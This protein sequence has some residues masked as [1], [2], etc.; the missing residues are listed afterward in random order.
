MERRA[1]RHL[2]RA[3]ELLGFGSNMNFGEGNKDDDENSKYYDPLTSND[4]QSSSGSLLN[5]LDEKLRAKIIR[6]LPLEKVEMLRAASKANKNEM[7]IGY[8]G[9]HPSEVQKEFDEHLRKKEMRLKSL[10]EKLEDYYKL[11]EQDLT[12]C[13]KSRD[14]MD[15]SKV[16]SVI[17]AKGLCPYIRT[18]KQQCREYGTLTGEQIWILFSNSIVKTKQRQKG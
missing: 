8:K 6:E 3:Q 15:L 7:V 1:R 17:S 14:E 18:I 11:T 5:K 13:L 12:Y 10:K 9:D 4:P 16:Q 2:Q